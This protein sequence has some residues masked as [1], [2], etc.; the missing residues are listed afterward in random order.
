MLRRELSIGLCLVALAC[1]GAVELVSSA[2]RGD[3]F[4]VALSG[5][6]AAGDGSAARP[7]RTIQHAVNVGIGAEGG[8][9]VL[10][11]DGTYAEQNAL[12]RGFPAPVVVRAEHPQRAVLTN[13]DGGGEAVRI[14]VD[15]PANLTLAGFVITNLHPTY[16]CDDGRESYYLIHIQDAQ[17]VT[18][19]DN[20]IFG[21]N[22]PG[23]CNEVLKINRG[24]E[25][26]YPRG[27]RV[28]GNVFYEP[29]N[30][31]GSDLIDSVRPG[32]L[33]IV[34]NLFFG[35]PDHPRSQSFITVKRQA[36]PPGTPNSPRYRVAR[37][38]FLHWGGASDQAFLQFGEDGVAEYEVTD[39]LVENNL[40]IGDSSA[41]L[42]APLQFKGVRGVR[43]RANTV[44]GD[45]PGG[46]YGLRIGTEGDNPTVGDITIHNNIWCDA[47][48]TMG[49]RFINAYG[50]VDLS[51]IMLESNL[52]WNGGN[53]LPTGGGILPEADAARIVEDPRLPADHSGIVLPSWDAD[54]RAFES[55]TTTIR[56]EFLRLVETYAALGEGSPAVDAADPTD[57]P[58]DDIRGYARDSAPDLG[59]YERGASD[60]PADVDAGADAGADAAPDP[61]A[62]SGGGADGGTAA[63]GEAGVDAGDDSA[64][65]DGGG[66]VAGYA[67]TAGVGGG[68]GDAGTEVARHP[69]AGGAAGVDTSV[70]ATDDDGGCGCRAATGDPASGWLGLLVA[71]GLLGGRRLRPARRRQPGRAAPRRSLD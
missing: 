51:S 42:A 32:E 27:I 52:F 6:D 43:V 66:T 13:V 58:A 69:N 30:A 57:M 59:A 53:A 28:E 33:E 2:A 36:P 20:V 40:F 65:G 21:N 24:S 45:L 56:D 61:D 4:H 34:G 26:A 71:L 46:A 16:A 8:H 60:L 41:S 7:W 47:T 44:V 14:Y 9:T 19:R 31:G 17:D 23:T 10:V 5:D 67:G 63:A 54:T 39:A 1:A 48:G 12:T 49:D 11:A 35:R 37:N 68:A 50:E 62:G 64:G 70:G 18:L 55:G 22:A 15:G 38:V 25:T 3:T 29:A